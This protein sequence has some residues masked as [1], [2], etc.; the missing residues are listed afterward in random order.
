[1]KELEML[2]EHFWIYKEENKELYYAIKDSTPKFKNFLNE[3]L[4]YHVIVNPSVIK[5]EKIPGRA[6]S[7]MGIEDFVDSMEYAFL[8][9]LLMFLED[10]TKEE[11]FVLSEI[12]EYIKGNFMG[13]EEVDWTLYRHRKHLIKVLKFAQEAHMIQVDDG[14]EQVFARSMDAEVLYESTGLS[15]YFVRSFGTNILEYRSYKDFEQEEWANL[16]KDRGFMRRHRVYRRL[17]MAPIMYNEGNEDADYDYVKKQ[18]G[19]IESDLEKYLGYNL[20]VHRNGALIVLD[21]EK[22]IKDTFPSTKA[23]SDVVLLFNALIVKK[24]KNHEISVNKGGTI[25]LSK[26]NFE[27]FVNELKSKTDHGWSKEYREMN[28][29]ILAER[30]LDYMEEFQMVSI[31]EM[32]KTVEIMPLVGKV[33]GTYPKDYLE[34]LEERN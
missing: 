20:H 10:K 18:R 15:R 34:N 17:L 5:L 7:F 16:D 30:I 33:I 11:Q 14:D 6:E 3:K 32:G 12:T 13:E 9:L 19:M 2:L 28:F 23:I 31:I 21:P 24:I 1:M 8:C 29:S 27:E 22:N 4:G 26:G 25:I